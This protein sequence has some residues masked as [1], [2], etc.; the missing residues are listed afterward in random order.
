MNGT[1]TDLAGTSPAAAPRKPVYQQ[2]GVLA[3]LVTMLLVMG[4]RVFERSYLRRDLASLL[5]GD[6]SGSGG[7]L[8]EALLGLVKVLPGPAVQQ[9]ALS[10]LAS[11]LVGIGLEVLYRRLRQA[12]WP[13]TG[14]VL[15]VVAVMLHAA[16][17]FVLT[18]D[19]GQIP[20]VIAL[21]VLVPAIRVGRRAGCGSKRAIRP[22]SR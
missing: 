2:P 12:L 14:A 6:A 13:V 4:Q 10:V 19:A 15:V 5:A 16:T 3:G 20:T 21:A 1:R 8:G 7:W 18:A 17:V 11:V 9:T 22:S